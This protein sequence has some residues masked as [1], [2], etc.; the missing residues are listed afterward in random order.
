MHLV[1]WRHTWLCREGNIHISHKVQPCVRRG[2][3][4][5]EWGVV[6]VNGQS[7]NQTLVNFQTVFSLSAKMFAVEQI[8]K[9]CGA[10]PK[11]TFSLKASVV[12][13]SLGLKI[14]S[15]FETS[16]TQ[17]DYFLHLDKHLLLDVGWNRERQKGC[18]VFV[19]LLCRLTWDMSYY[20]A[21][22]W[23]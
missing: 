20:L 16:K 4:V 23:L 3:R 11:I 9:S 7:G 19:E 14:E 2:S 22:L 18:H 15:S 6:S 17:R 13:L 8:R 12:N 21:L 1:S 5:Q 10:P